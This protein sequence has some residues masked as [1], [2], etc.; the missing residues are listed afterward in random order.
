MTYSAMRKTII[1]TLID[2]AIEQVKRFDA[3]EVYV[4][5]TTAVPPGMMRGAGTLQRRYQ[6]NNAFEPVSVAEALRGK[7]D[8]QYDANGQVINVHREG[9]VHRQLT[10]HG[11]ARRV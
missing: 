5:F 2:Q 1:K 6:W 4:R 7:T 9:T 8:Y 10:E 3:P 11:A